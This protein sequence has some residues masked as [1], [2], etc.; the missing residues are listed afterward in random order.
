MRQIIIIDEELCT[1]IEVLQYEVEARKEIIA[2]ILS[3][4]IAEESPMFEKY[5][6]EY[7]KYFKAY[8]D[9]KRKMLNKYSVANNTPWSLNFQTRELTLN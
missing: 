9:T 4:D 3:S 1:E 7:A 8:N 2:K 6:K 5:Q